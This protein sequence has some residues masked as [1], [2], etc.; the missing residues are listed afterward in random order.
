MYYE[1]RKTE[2]TINEDAGAY[3]KDGC[4][5]LVHMGVCTEA[6]WPYDIN[7]F[8]VQPPDKVL[9]E[10]AKY[11]IT[12]YEKVLGIGNIKT[13]LASGYVLPAAMEVFAQM[14]SADAAQTGIVRVPSPRET[15][16][17]GHAICIVGYTDTPRGPNYWKGGGYI[18]IRNSW[19]DKWGDRGYFRVAYDYV[20]LGYLFEAWKVS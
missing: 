5:I 14:E 9:P 10:A 12:K 20:N 8:K 16:M 17:G 6:S 15:S 4:D 13:C 19:G 11:V 1:E 18:T 2:G 7:N 3:L